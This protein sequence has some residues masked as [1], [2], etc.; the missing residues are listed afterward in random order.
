MISDDRT[1][2]QIVLGLRMSMER[3]QKQWHE[4]ARF[5]PI[6]AGLSLEPDGLVLGRGTV[7][8]PAASSGRRR[9]QLEGT[10]A[11]ALTLLSVAYGRPVSL[12]VFKHVHKA[13]RQ[14]SL[15]EDCL[16]AIHLAFARLPKLDE[17]RE[18]AKRLFIADGMIAAGTDL[19][20]VLAAFGLAPPD[21]YRKLFDDTELRV[22]PGNGRASGEWTAGSA[23]FLETLSETDLLAL[24]GFAARVMAPVAT[25]GLLII[26]TS[27]GG[28]RMEGRI[29]G[30]GDLRYAWDQD[31]T[32]LQITQ[33]TG[34]IV[35]SAN[36]GADG[37]FYDDRKQVV[38][39]ILDNRLLLDTAAIRAELPKD[40]DE[41]EDPKLCPV[42]GKDKAGRTSLAGEKDKD[43]EDYVKRQINPAN[44]TPRGFGVQLPNP[45]G[46]RPVNYDDC[47]R[48]T[49]IL[50][51]AKGTGYAGP[52]AREK[53]F[54]RDIFGAAW[55]AQAERQVKASG[56]RPIEWHFAEYGA[57]EYARKIFKDD[58]LLK[59]VTVI[60]TPWSENDD[61]L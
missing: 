57:A 18:A 8:V 51:E 60:Y 15:G 41:D 52:I 40:T 56:G 58:C 46:G 29:E 42:P 45:A 7:L 11:R 35:L 39:R 53:S 13:S 26:P 17:P 31:E 27:T 55:R 14:W 1:R 49:G 61:G 28:R 6:H 38:G 59:N 44:P 37:Q 25:L 10:E 12:A 23:S 54:M 24:A 16:A 34:K 33:G 32:T 2:K 3:L 22:L 30:D 5:R 21:S 36:L 19:R 43:Y 47:Q 9:L 48:Q 20:D 4:S 50:I